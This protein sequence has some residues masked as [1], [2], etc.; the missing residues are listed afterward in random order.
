M[1][2]L[3]ASVEAVSNAALA[4]QLFLYFQ[5]P[6]L[7]KPLD[8]HNCSKYLLRSFY[9]CKKLN[10]WCPG[11]VLR[12]ILISQSQVTLRGALSY[13]GSVF[14][15]GTGQW[16]GGAML[17]KKIWGKVLIFPV[18]NMNMVSYLCLGLVERQTGNE[19]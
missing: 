11:P 16:G 5:S 1:P 14:I 15:T 2:C 10:T 12:K 3:P 4:P 8:S 9:V 7:S 13:L 6:H 19:V 17:G 18:C